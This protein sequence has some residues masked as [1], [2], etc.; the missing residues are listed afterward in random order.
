MI[1]ARQGKLH[2]LWSAKLDSA[3]SGV[4]DNPSGS[5]KSP[6]FPQFMLPWWRADSQDVS[7]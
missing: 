7:L 6:A 1:A 2:P 4:S 5:A 3:R